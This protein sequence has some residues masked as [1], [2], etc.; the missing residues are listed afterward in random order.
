[1]YIGFMMKIKSIKF[2]KI[3][4]YYLKLEAV[5]LLQFRKTD[6]FRKLQPMA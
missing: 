6:T 5:K 2:N 1:M 3:I 4:D